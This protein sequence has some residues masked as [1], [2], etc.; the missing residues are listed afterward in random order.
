[1]AQLL[2]FVAEFGGYFVILGFQGGFQLG[3]ELFRRY[4]D[5]TKLHIQVPNTM[6]GFE[7]AL[8]RTPSDAK[9]VMV[10]TGTDCL[11]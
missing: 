4:A 11:N 2:H 8:S 5:G 9:F 6:E 1:L 3:L 7:Q 10:A